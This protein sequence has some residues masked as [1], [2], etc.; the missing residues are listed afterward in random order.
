MIYCYFYLD[1]TQLLF[2]IYLNFVL[3][4]FVVTNFLF[5]KFRSLVIQIQRVYRE[6]P[7]SGGVLLVTINNKY[8]S[9]YW[10][11]RMCHYI[12]VSWSICVCVS[13][14]QILW[15]WGTLR[16]KLRLQ[17]GRDSLGTMSKVICV[18]QDRERYICVI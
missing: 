1:V 4:I 14:P 15:I 6:M 11:Y 17:L 3:L 8:L 2:A 5:A 10:L 13:G 18:K 7:H 9:Y 16:L 12:G